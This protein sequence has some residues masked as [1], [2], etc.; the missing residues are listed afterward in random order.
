MYMVNISMAT[1]LFPPSGTMRS[2]YRLQGSMNCWCMG[3]SMRS[4]GIA[5]R[6]NSTRHSEKI[7]IFVRRSRAIRLFKAHPSLFWRSALFR[8]FELYYYSIVFPLLQ[9]LSYR[10]EKSLFR[11]I[12]SAEGSGKCGL[13]EGRRKK[14]ERKAVQMRRNVIYFV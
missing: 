3:F 4:K 14:G 5:A 6:A 9:R 13:C 11:G 7:V 8:H 10:F 12:F 2:A 1:W